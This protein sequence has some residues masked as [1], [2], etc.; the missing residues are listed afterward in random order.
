MP[1]QIVTTLTDSA[2]LFDGVP[3]LGSSGPVVALGGIIPAALAIEI[4]P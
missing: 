1:K 4:A 3:T 2:I